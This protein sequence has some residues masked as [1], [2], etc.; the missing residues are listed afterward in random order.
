MTIVSMMGYPG[1]TVGRVL[2]TDYATGAT[3][4]DWD[5]APELANFTEPSSGVYQANIT[6]TGRWRIRV[7]DNTNSLIFAGFASDTQPDLS[8]T[9]PW[10]ASSAIMLPAQVT[11]N[12]RSFANVLEFMTGETAPFS[13]AVRDASGALVDLTG[14]TLTLIFSVDETQIASVSV[15]V[16][17]STITFNTPSAVTADEIQEGKW[18]LREP[19][20]GNLGVASGIFNTRYSP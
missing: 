9:P 15:T 6:G 12:K 3:V 8:S 11:T 5:T 2:V 10:A 18:T 19:S 14:K 17:G 1:Q 7:W 16:S 4:A 20:N 13:H